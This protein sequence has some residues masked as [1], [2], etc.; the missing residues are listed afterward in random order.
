MKKI[1]VVSKD[2]LNEVVNENIEDAIMNL[3]MGRPNVQFCGV[4][5]GADEMVSLELVKWADIILVLE[6]WQKDEL[7]RIIPEAVRKDIR[8]LDLLEEDLE[9]KELAKRTIKRIL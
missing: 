2:G 4:E 5:I 3:G 7:L 6:R 9:H 8:L 1:L